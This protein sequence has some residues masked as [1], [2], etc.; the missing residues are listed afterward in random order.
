MALGPIHITMPNSLLRSAAWTVVH[1]PENDTLRISPR[2]LHLP[3]EVDLLVFLGGG[4]T[5]SHAVWRVRSN[6]VVLRMD[7]AGLA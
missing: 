3:V 2:A 6:R 7:D 5:T 4:F 1:D